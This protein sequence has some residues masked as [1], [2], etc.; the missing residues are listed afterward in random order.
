VL[1]DRVYNK[2]I[3][4][5]SGIDSLGNP[6]PDPALPVQQ[7]YGTGIRPRQS[8]F[9]DQNQAAKVVVEYLNRIFKAMLMRQTSNLTGLFAQEPIPPV[10]SGEYDLVVPNYE[11]L[12]FVNII[13]RPVGY[14][15][16]V[17]NDSNVNGLWSVYTKLANNTWFLSRVQTYKVSEYWEYVNWFADGYDESLVPN[18]VVYQQADLSTLNLVSGDIVKIQNDGTGNWKFVK[19][20]PYAVVT[21]GVQ[22][23]TVQ[24]KSSLWD[25][26]TAGFGWDNDTFDT[27][28]FDQNPSI[29]IRS[30]I[31]TIIDQIL[32]NELSLANTKLI[33][34]IMK[35]AIIIAINCFVSFAKIV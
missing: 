17:E 9:I 27:I 14:K 5:L 30:L 35:L 6:V 7:R 24:L 16:L 4:S 22:N 3:D 1:P 10:G 2:I 20:L 26:E 11:T 21:I 34:V 28:R 29:E 13:I 33:F 23:G 19:V 25:F 12:G 8:I 18:Y 31:S 32:I 15:I